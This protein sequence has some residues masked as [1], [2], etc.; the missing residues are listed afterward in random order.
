LSGENRGDQTV[1]ELQDDFIRR[2]VGNERKAQDHRSPAK[3]GDA[4]SMP[5]QACNTG[6][7]ADESTAALAPAS[8]YPG[9]A[10]KPMGL[11]PGSDTRA[12]AALQRTEAA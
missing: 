9:S 4:L 1:N 12:S 3:V 10:P 11:V 7:G 8:N 2:A 5:R 6:R